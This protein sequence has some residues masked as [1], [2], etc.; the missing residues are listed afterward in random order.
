MSLAHIYQLDWIYYHLPRRWLDSQYSIIFQCSPFTISISHIQT[1]QTKLSFF[2]VVYQD[3]PATPVSALY[4]A[5]VVE[6]APIVDPKDENANLKKY[7]EIIKS[8]QVKEAEII[9]FPEATLNSVKKPA[10]VPQ[11]NDKVVA[12]DS[13]KFSEV[14]KSISC[15]AKETKKYVVVN[16]FM[17]RNCKEEK[18]ESKG[19]D[20]RPCTTGEINIYNTAIAFDRS[21]SIVAM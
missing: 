14:V 5:A 18:E 12:C 9:V 21:G 10:I 1:K 17:Q 16:L 20:T 8:D 6:Y 11:L 4:K 19:N 15:A 3:A 2:V 13:D 7:I